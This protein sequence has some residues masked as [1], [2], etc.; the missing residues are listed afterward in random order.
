MDTIR[1]FT[2][3]LLPMAL[4]IGLALTPAAFAADPRSDAVAAKIKAMDTNGDGLVSAAEYAAHAKAEFDAM[5]TNHNGL[6]TAAEMD[7]ARA[8]FKNP[9]GRQFSSAAIIKSMDTNGDGMLSAEEYATAAETA[10]NAM[11]TNHSGQL[12]ADE[13]RIAYDAD[14]ASGRFVP[15]MN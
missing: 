14:L 2:R 3:A 8:K 1:L 10:F 6:V 5:D 13:I 11:D 7:A 15:G 9:T 4:C 12:T